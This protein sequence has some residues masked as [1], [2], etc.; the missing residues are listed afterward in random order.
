MYKYKL[1]YGYMIILFPSYNLVIF[2]LFYLRN[3]N[4]Y[5]LFLIRNDCSFLPL[6]SF[7]RA[8]VR[9]RVRVRVCVC[10]FFKRFHEI[11]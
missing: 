10:V 8:R 4:V 7:L 1:P 11:R 2:A 6:F 5:I 3:R 9:A